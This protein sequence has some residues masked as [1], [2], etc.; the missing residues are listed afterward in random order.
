MS[1]FHGSKR[2]GSQQPVAN[3][4]EKK[5]KIDMYDFPLHNCPQDQNSSPYFSSIVQRGKYL[6]LSRKIVEILKFCYHGN[7]TSH[8]SSLFFYAYKKQETTS[9]RKTSSRGTNWRLPLPAMNVNLRPWPNVELFMRRTKLSELSSWKVPPLA[10]VSSSE[11]VSI[12]QHVL[13][14][15]F[16][17]LERFVFTPARIKILTR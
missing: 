16:R 3:M 4:A 17:R 13:S 7:L 15:C 11:W 2:S 12:V 5:Q 8:F 1:R 10:Q 6:S 14:V 9:K